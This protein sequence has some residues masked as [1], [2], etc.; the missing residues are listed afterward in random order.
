MP[1][2]TARTSSTPSRRTRTRE[3]QAPK[4]S[5][6]PRLK[7][8]FPRNLTRRLK[9]D[10]YSIV[11]EFSQ[12]AAIALLLYGGEA[13]IDFF[14][15]RGGHAWFVKAIEV[16]LILAMVWR[17]LRT[18]HSENARR[19]CR[20]ESKSNADARPLT[21]P[22]AKRGLARALDIPEESIDIRIR[23]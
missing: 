17:W 9:A 3:L 20:K 14:R 7:W 11:L 1:D 8:L 19:R 22:E 21:V 6:R 23:S 4:Q 18:G 16:V 2:F 12:V 13:I 5:V 10:G 15:L